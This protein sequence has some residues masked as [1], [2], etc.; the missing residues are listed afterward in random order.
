MAA[1]TGESFDVFW[2]AQLAIPV[3]A[4][5]QGDK[6]ITE[7]QTARLVAAR[8]RVRP[9]V[10]RNQAASAAQ[11]DWLATFARGLL[12]TEAEILV[13]RPDRSDDYPD[14]AF[15]T[16]IHDAHAQPRQSA[17]IQTAYLIPNGPTVANL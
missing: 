11:A 2:N 1:D 3:S 8:E 5:T 12:W 10:E 9:A 14:S 4:L 16:F 7:E 13:D 6:Q 15:M 17:V